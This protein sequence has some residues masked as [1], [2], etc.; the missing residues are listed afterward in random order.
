VGIINIIKKETT[1]MTTGMTSTAT[2][3]VPTTFLNKKQLA[4]KAMSKAIYQ[5]I[6]ESSV[7]QI[8]PVYLFNQGGNVPTEIFI[9]RT[10]DRLVIYKSWNSK[11]IYTV[12]VIHNSN[13]TLA[14]KKFFSYAR[15]LQEARKELELIDELSVI[16]YKGETSW[17]A[18]AAQVGTIGVL[19]IETPIDIC[20]IRF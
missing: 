19:V 12:N 4:I 7:A 3:T 15:A 10:E 17:R 11:K 14:E 5:K 6:Q 2:T 16:P 18:Y 13:F 9:G 8:F 20:A 1:E